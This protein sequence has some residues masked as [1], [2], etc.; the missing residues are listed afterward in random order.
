MPSQ[1]LKDTNL[2]MNGTM[3]MLIF[4]DASLTVFFPSDVGSFEDECGELVSM[5]P[6]R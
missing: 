5:F 4:V 1:V 6:T 2:L 3:H